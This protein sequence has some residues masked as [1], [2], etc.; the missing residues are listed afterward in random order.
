MLERGWR[1]FKG[2]DVVV[3][4]VDIPI[5][6]PSQSPEPKSAWSGSSSPIESTVAGTLAAPHIARAAGPVKIGVLHP[7][8]GYAFSADEAP[9]LLDSAWSN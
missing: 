2:R 6:L 8:T 5:G 1:A 4:G 3:V 9:S 7:V